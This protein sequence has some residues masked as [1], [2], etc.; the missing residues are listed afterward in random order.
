RVVLRDIGLPETAL[1]TIKP[2]CW[3]NIPGLW[4]LPRVNEE[5][6]KFD[7]GHVLVV[8]GCALQTGA[9]RLAA[10]GALRSGA[11]L[12]TLAGARDALEEHA[13]HVTAIMLRE[14]ATAEGL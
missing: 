7:R 6:H 12:V 5:G 11:G 2:Q 9:S 3:H 13:A 1:D 14:A 10:L 8:S 4:N